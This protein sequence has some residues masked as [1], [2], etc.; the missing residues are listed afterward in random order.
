V[1]VLKTVKVPAGM[2]GAFA[3]AEEL[4]A[5]WFAD[6]RDVPERG[7]IE[8]G[9]ERY[10]LVRA[11][12]LSV[13]FFAL[14]RR[15]Y[16]AGRE[17]EADAFALN[18]LFD[19]AH[20]LGKSDAAQFHTRMGVTDPIERLSAGPVHFAHSGW[21]FV[22]ILAESRPSPD[23]DFFL[24]YDHPYSFESDAWVRAGQRAPQ[25]V[26]IMN[27]GYS[28]G[29]CEESF[30]VQLVAAELTC[31]A[32]GDERCR[33]V[34][35]HPSRIEQ[36]VQRLGPREHAA[37]PDFFARKRI[38]EELR[39][40]RA[41]LEVRV[42]ERTDELR[43][44]MTI[45]QEAE[46]R[47][48]QRD[49]LEALG[50]LAGGVAH[51][52]NNL[53]AVVL[54]NCGLLARTFEASDRRRALTDEIALAGERAADLTGQLL[55]FGRAQSLERAP[56]DVSRV[57]GDLARLLARLLGEDVELRLELAPD[58]GQVLADRGRLEQVVVN[59]AVNA[60]EAMPRGG[61]LIIACDHVELDA[62]ER[63]LLA[64]TSP[65]LR[66]VRIVVRD[67][68][69]GMDEATRAKI[70]DP[71][72]TT[73]ERGTGLGLSTVHGI[74]RDLGG[75]IAVESAP[76]HG[77][78]MRVFLPVAPAASAASVPGVAASPRPAA[79]RATILLV[80][81]QQALRRA[82]ARELGEL[83]HDIVAVGDAEAALLEARGRRFDLMI[84]DLM[85]PRSTGDELAE[86]LW[87][88]QPELRVLFMSGR[89]GVPE[90]AHA[91]SGGYAFLPKPFTVSA[92]EV[93]LARL[94][95]AE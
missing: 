53:M 68:G 29:W 52:F 36:H 13:D 35:A 70:F 77:T 14:V 20:A 55:A 56:I 78:A 54:T 69:V 63:E 38:E 28:S 18:I 86:T 12:G 25:P 92:L 73:K 27:A 33:F 15:L 57:I 21:A 84:T 71:F 10:V 87:R 45:R 93:E 88:E 61:V 23:E 75:A 51:D 72:F 50:R 59:L 66:F 26:C 67:T 64:S 62:T 42:R 34:M 79:R 89:E 91:P 19:L 46:R 80:E 8:L 17:D 58:A 83:G 43:R 47:L 65:G 4:V 60:R 76:G 31:R 41:E 24:F 3:H 95:P 32:H 85:L 30:G 81:D 74:V 9:G 48:Q 40:A 16:G 49:K 94:L 2:E 22:D 39:R 5:R 11:A 1:V 37:I 7:T 44:E 82:L 6:R 90:L